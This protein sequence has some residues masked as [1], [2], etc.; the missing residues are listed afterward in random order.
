M[1]MSRPRSVLLGVVLTALAMAGTV[2]SASAV[3]VRPAIEPQPAAATTSPVVDGPACPDVMV[4]GA[5]GTNE[6]PTTDWQTLNA[7]ASDQN[8]GVG[9]TPCL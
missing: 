1:Q 8:L 7:Y 9:P 6:A 3:S 2:S 4:I 5:R